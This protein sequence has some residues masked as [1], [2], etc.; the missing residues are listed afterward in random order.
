VF[1]SK[2][3]LN[4]TYSKAHQGKHLSDTVPVRNGL[5][6]EGDAVSLLLFNFFRTC[7]LEAPRKPGGT[8]TEWATS[9]ADLC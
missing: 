2:I 3:Y 6:L 4:E 5:A 9:G 1:V 8:E 7:H